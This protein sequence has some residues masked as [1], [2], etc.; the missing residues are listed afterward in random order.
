M[1]IGAGRKRVD[2]A[3][4]G[5]ALCISVLEV[6]GGFKPFYDPGDMIFR[7]IFMGNPLDSYLYRG[8]CPPVPPANTRGRGL[9]RTRHGHLFCPPDLIVVPGVRGQRPRHRCLGRRDDQDVPPALL[10]RI[11]RSGNG[12]MILCGV[13]LRRG[14]KDPLTGDLQEFSSRTLEPRVH[15]RFYRAEKIYDFRVL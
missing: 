5:S 12:V 8:A 9:Q 2:H 4:D 15:A 1:A 11:G 6:Y 14:N 13:L 7:I 10:V 3:G